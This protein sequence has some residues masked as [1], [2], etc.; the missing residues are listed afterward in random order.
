MDDQRKSDEERSREAEK[1]LTELQ[2]EAFM[3]AVT[4]LPDKMVAVAMDK[5]E[6]DVKGYLKRVREYFEV[7]LNSKSMKVSIGIVVEIGYKDILFDKYRD[8][9][10]VHIERYEKAVEV[11]RRKLAGK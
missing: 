1:Y 11:M 9:H 5:S 8:K 6:N 3:L 4:G 10:R 7:D 2:Q